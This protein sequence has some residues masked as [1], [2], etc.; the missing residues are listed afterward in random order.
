[1]GQPGCSAICINEYVKNIRL[2]TFAPTFAIFP[3]IF[4][5]KFPWYLPHNI[6]EYLRWKTRRGVREQ[7]NSNRSKYQVCSSGWGCC[8]HNQITKLVSETGD[9][10]NNNWCR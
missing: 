2:H 1:M 5:S 8:T 9:D 4:S 6:I 3:K 7:I 10:W